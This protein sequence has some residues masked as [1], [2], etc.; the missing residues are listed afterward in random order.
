MPRNNVV[1][2]T[3]SPDMTTAVDHGPKTTTTTNP[4]SRQL[5]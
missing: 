5:L 3:D 4:F 1:R 2:L